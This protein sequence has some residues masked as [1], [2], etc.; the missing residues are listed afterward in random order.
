MVV[1]RTG[2]T[3]S[4]LSAPRRACPTP[5][6]S[7]AARELKAPPPSGGRRPSVRELRRTRIWRAAK[8]AAAGSRASRKG[9][10]GNAHARSP[11][12]KP[13]QP[14]HHVPRFGRVEC[15][16]N[17]PE[18]SHGSRGGAQKRRVG[19]ENQGHAQLDYLVQ[20][21][22]GGKV[23]LHPR[24]QS[25]AAAQ[26]AGWLEGKEGCTNYLGGQRELAA[27]RGRPSRHICSTTRRC[28]VAAVGGGG[29]ARHLLASRFRPLGTRPRRPEAPRPPAA[30]RPGSSEASSR[31]FPAAQLWSGGRGAPVAVADAR[32]RDSKGRGANHKRR[33]EPNAR[34]GRLQYCGTTARTPTPKAL[35][36]EPLKS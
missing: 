17:G 6:Q 23:R 16:V 12:A 18:N 14:R 32:R 30:Q 24:T 35:T 22:R 19:R 2:R 33:E 8:W 9:A 28:R 7:R 20:N 36:A 29:A 11:V 26:E 3:P 34:S 4:A 31:P 15:G 5:P 1:R 21:S 13:S 10:T 25:Q 27:R